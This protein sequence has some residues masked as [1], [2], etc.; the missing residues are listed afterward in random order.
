MG[1][2]QKNNAFSNKT[3][4][5]KKVN[6]KEY[7]CNI[8]DKH[9]RYKN[10]IDWAKKNVGYGWIWAKNDL[11]KNSKYNRGIK[12][13]DSSD[14]ILKK[15]PS[16]EDE[17]NDDYGDSVTTARYYDKKSGLVV[18]KNFYYGKNQK[19]TKAIWW[20]Y[21]PKNKANIIKLN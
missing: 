12:Y 21:N 19:I 11:T 17:G 7:T 16:W 4:K 18:Y 15:Y 1:G 3:I 2:N 14:K 10:F 13:G 6:R 9:K 8:V 5:D 20:S